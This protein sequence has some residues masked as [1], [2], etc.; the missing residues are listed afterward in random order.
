MSRRGILRPERIN[1]PQAR[2]LSLLAPHGATPPHPSGRHY[3]YD[4]AQERIVR[5]HAMTVKALVSRDLLARGDGGELS[6]TP[7]GIWA[8]EDYQRRTERT[9]A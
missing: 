8:L 3:I 9:A 7:A 4:P 1:P 6:V 2:V 5:L